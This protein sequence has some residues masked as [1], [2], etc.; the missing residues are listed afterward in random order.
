MH[1]KFLKT[2]LLLCDNSNLKRPFNVNFMLPKALKNRQKLIHKF[3]YTGLQSPESVKS[4]Q[5][6]QVNLAHLRVDF[7]A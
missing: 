2:F 4:I 7:Q 1:P 6:L 5:S 3:S